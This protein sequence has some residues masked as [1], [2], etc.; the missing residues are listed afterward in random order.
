[1]F[2]DVKSIKRLLKLRRKTE[3][4]IQA[5]EPLETQELQC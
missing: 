2:E 4:P 1:L 3:R 5:E